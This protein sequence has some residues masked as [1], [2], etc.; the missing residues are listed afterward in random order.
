METALHGAGRVTAL[1]CGTIYDPHPSVRE[2]SLVERI[3]RGERRLELP[4][5][6]AQVWHRVAVD[7]VGNAIAAA[8][9]P[10]R[11]VLR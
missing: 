1:R 9:Q 10:P 2:S 6:G 11:S 4:D 7:R 5:G 8:D 3:A